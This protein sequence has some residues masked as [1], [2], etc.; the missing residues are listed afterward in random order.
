MEAQ[1]VLFTWTVQNA[2]EEAIIVA[3]DDLFARQYADLMG[4]HGPLTKIEQPS[5]WIRELDD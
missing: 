5:V 2:T 3:T 1:M 4:F